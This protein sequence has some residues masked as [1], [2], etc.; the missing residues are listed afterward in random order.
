MYNESH[1]GPLWSDLERSRERKSIRQDQT[2]K[3]GTATNRDLHKSEVGKHCWQ[4]GSFS[5]TLRAADRQTD[6][7]KRSCDESRKS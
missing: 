3:M 1:T 7:A 5:R 6:R 2:L 4:R